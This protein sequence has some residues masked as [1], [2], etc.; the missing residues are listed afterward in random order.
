LSVRISDIA[1]AT[2]SKN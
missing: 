2:L 1:D